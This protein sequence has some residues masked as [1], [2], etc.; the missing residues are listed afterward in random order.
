MGASPLYVGILNAIHM[1]SVLM[2]LLTMRQVQCRGKRYVIVLWYG[3]AVLMTAPLVF[4][5]DV[6]YYWGTT[7]RYSALA[8]FVIVT[9]AR[10]LAIG[11]GT[12]AWMPLIQDNTTET[13]RGR[14]LGKMRTWT[15]AA[16]LLWFAAMVA[17]VG[18]DV[19]WPV[20]RIVFAIGLA[21]AILR[22][23][24]LFPLVEYPP[25]EKPTPVA[26]MFREPF[27]DRRFRWALVYVFSYG[28]GIGLA[29]PFR[30]VYLK[31]LGYDDWVVMFGPAAMFVGGILTFTY[32]GILADSVGNR[33]LFGISHLGMFVCLVA[34]LIVD[35]GTLGLV[36]GV[37]LFALS[38]VFN[39]A[40]N[41]AKT[42]YVL[43][44]TPIKQQVS[45]LTMITI[46]T[47]ATT[48]VSSLMGG[49]F[50]TWGHNL[51][52]NQE[53]TYHVLFLLSGL[54][55]CLSYPISQK[56]RSD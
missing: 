30:V 18:K 48:G 5:P 28:L 19:S 46:L 16:W 42:R 40:N 34:W 21:A 33:A 14:F 56:L 38:G 47:T 43:S 52:L 3:F 31:A 35:K 32:W 37:S 2:Q 54:L 25:P 4:L 50:L 23:L 9:A 11:L 45:Y 6:W 39:G 26:Q 29:L 15:Q 51:G 24:C 10:H 12:T 41:I 1:C 13:G 20:I 49:L 8:F 17:C 36:V 55:I 53:A 27:R 44:A 7:S 22:V